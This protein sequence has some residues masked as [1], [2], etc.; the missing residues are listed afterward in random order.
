MSLSNH[1]DIPAFLNHI[2][3]DGRYTFIDEVNENMD[4]AETQ[5]QGIEDRMEDALDTLHGAGM[6]YGMAATIGSGLSVDV[7]AGRALIG[8][9]VSYAGGSVSVLANADPGYIWFCQ[10]GTWEVNVTGTA[11]AAKAA[12]L[13]SRYTSGASTVTAILDANVDPVQVL[14]CTLRRA[15][16]TFAQVMPAYLDEST[17]VVNHSAQVDFVIPGRIH[18]Y[19]S[20]GFYIE[21]MYRGCVSDDSETPNDPPLEDT[22]TLFW[23]KLTRTGEYIA[24]GTPTSATIEYIR[25]GFAFAE[26]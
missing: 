15:Y 2:E 24:S 3:G 14:P 10:D 9:E 4:D 5:L 26:S 18:L 1:R 11:P 8:Y 17:F 19:V 12:F 25:Y 16:G 6:I 22:G 23:I 21:H 7:A 20:E 13:L